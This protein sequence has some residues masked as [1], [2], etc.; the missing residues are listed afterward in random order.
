[1]LLVIC[2][3]YPAKLPNIYKEF[4]C[5]KSHPPN[6]E[7]ARCGVVSGWLHL[8]QSLRRPRSRQPTASVP[9]RSVSSPLSSLLRSAVPAASVSARSV[10]SPV[11]P[12]EIT[13]FHYPPASPLLR[14]GTICAQQRCGDNDRP[15]LPCSLSARSRA[16]REGAPS[17]YAPLRPCAPVSGARPPRTT[18]ARSWVLKAAW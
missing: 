10:F 18:A 16:G 9:A 2:S 13:R 5:G 11:L 7:G 17:P 3:R 12:V 8:R 4:G 15:C 6:F 1:M 14:N